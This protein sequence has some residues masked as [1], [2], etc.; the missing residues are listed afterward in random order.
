MEALVLTIVLNLI[1][2][3]LYDHI[4]V[5]ANKFFDQSEQTVIQAVKDE[6]RPLEGK[7]MYL[8]RAVRS[9]PPF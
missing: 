5:W 4:K 6:V 2:S 9:P 7:L 3:G 1:S 8:A